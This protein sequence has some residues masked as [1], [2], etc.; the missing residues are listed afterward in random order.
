MTKY[1]IAVPDRQLCCAPVDSPEG[2]QYLGAMKAAAN[3]AAAN[4]Q[5]IAEAVRDVFAGFFP[6]EK[7]TTVYDV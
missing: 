2:R 1:G 3:F 5:A 6:G 4:R 7:L